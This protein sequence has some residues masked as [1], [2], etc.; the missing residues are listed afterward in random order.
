MDGG[1]ERDC[2]HC[3]KSIGG[4]RRKWLGC[5][6]F[7]WG[8]TGEKKTFLRDRTCVLYVL[9]HVGEE[10]EEK[11]E[12]EEEEEEANKTNFEGEEEEEIAVQSINPKTHTQI[13]VRYA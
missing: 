1:G 2:L 4:W 8:W 12:E 7:Q 13:D 10:E 11:E 6:C 3:M 9:V 5:V